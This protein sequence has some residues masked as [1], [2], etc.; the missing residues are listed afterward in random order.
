VTEHQTS[1]PESEV[2]ARI[3]ER[4]TFHNAENGLAVLR[5]KARG[6]RDHVTFVGHAAAISAGKWI[7]ATCAWVNDRTHGQ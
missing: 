3:V 6:H 5:V 7:I 2:L 1:W 4:V